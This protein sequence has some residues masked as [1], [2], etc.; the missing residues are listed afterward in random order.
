MVNNPIKRLCRVQSL[1]I[2]FMSSTIS[3]RT[4]AEITDITSFLRLPL[5]GGCRCSTNSGNCLKRC[6]LVARSVEEKSLTTQ[7]TICAWYSVAS[8]SF[9]NCNSH[10]WLHYQLSRNKRLR[11]TDETWCE[12]KIA[13][14]WS[15]AEKIQMSGFLTL[16]YTR[17]W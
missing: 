10:G 6:I 12:V 7:G 5:T 14:D 16:C 11:K 13:E 4:E 17:L 1:E 8:R 2:K 3:R 9:P 15:F